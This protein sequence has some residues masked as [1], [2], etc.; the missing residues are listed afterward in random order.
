MA[1]TAYERYKK[2]TR[3]DNLKD[4]TDF[5][6]AMLSALDQ[7]SAP[8]KPVKWTMGWGFK[9]SPYK[10]DV[11]ALTLATTLSPNLNFQLSLSEFK[12]K[13][14]NVIKPRLANINKFIRDVSGLRE[15]DYISGLD[16]IAKGVEMGKWQLSG[17]IDQLITI[18]TDIVTGLIGLS[19]IHI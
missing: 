6:K 1:D 4:Y 13:E 10:G 15:K 11:G 7:M 19:L 18:P 2:D 17:A 9:D 3:K 12:D 5:Q 16:E 14:G 8:K